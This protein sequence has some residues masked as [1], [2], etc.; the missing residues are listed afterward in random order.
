MGNASETARGNQVMAVNVSGRQLD[1]DQLIDDI[2]DALACSGM[3][4]EALTIEI[5]ETTLMRDVEQTARRLGAIKDLGV[6]PDKPN[7]AVS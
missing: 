4:P 7:P 6:N 3:P 5:T 1:S 2:R